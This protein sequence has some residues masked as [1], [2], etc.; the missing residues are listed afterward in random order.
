MIISRIMGGLGNQMFQYV[1]GWRLA[2][3][4]GVPLKLDLS[5]FDR[6]E[7]RKF[8][9]DQFDLDISLAN[10]DYLRE[11]IPFSSIRLVR[12]LWR[13]VHNRL[14]ENRGFVY[15]EKQIGYFDPDVLKVGKNKYLDGYWQSEKYFKK[16]E[17]QVRSLFTP[18]DPLTDQDQAL[19]KEMSGNP[20]S[21]SVHIRCGDYISQQHIIRGHYIC[22]P[23]YYKET[24][25]LLVERFGDSA[26]FYIF[27]DDPDW[28][29]SNIAFPA[30]FKIVSNQ[31]RST[32]QEMILMSQCQN[33]IIA[34]SS[35]SWWG[36]WLIDNSAKFVLYPEKWFYNHAAPDTPAEGWISH[37]HDTSSDWKHIDIPF[38]KSRYREKYNCE[39]DLDNPLKF[40]EKLQWLKIYDRRPIYTTTSDKFAVRQYVADRIGEQY[41]PK[42]YGVYRSSKEIDWESLP[43][44][45]VLKANHGSKWNFYCKDKRKLNITEVSRQV[46]D[47]MTKNYFYPGRESNYKHISPRIIC[48]EYLEDEKGAALKDY[49]FYCFNGRVEFIHVDVNRFTDHRRAIFDTDW[50]LLPFTIY[51]LLPE[52]EISRPTKLEKMISLACALTDGFPFFRVDLFFIG[53][54][55]YFGELTLCPVSGFP[56]IRPPEYDRI[57]GEKLI[58][59]DEKM[60]ISE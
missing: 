33:A 60:T 39:L 26:Y 49:M 56:I 47:W 54:L 50:N 23:Q 1:L 21:V 3:E 18:K 58:L 30:N 37:Q 44:K 24:M 7:K 38:A 29:R 22:T 6:Q 16:Y 43:N 25:Q 9:L 2:L 35:Y 31:Q 48:E 10:K 59:P 41:L 32:G 46:D 57:L 20:H 45:F 13:R 17:D 4:H 36:A 5:W 27:S 14:P 55:I 34:N 42:L 8:E 19:A 51:Y 11:L 28:C 40:S 53:E 15:R 12:G 52:E